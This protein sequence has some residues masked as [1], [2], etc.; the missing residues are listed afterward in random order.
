MRKLQQSYVKDSEKLYAFTFIKEI[1]KNLIFSH[2]FTRM[3]CKMRKNSKTILQ[4][5]LSLHDDNGYLHI[6]RPVCYLSSPSELSLLLCLVFF[7]FNSYDHPAKT[8]CPCQTPFPF[9][10]T[11]WLS[12]YGARGVILQTKQ[13]KNCHIYPWLK[14]INGSI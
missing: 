13:D 1:R 9:R 5:I 4:L 11:H 6:W 7:S 2:I 10:C 14:Q 3:C 8:G 12:K